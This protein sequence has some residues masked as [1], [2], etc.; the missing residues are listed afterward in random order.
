M[1]VNK[2]MLQASMVAL[3]LVCFS[4]IARAGYLV[5]L[6]FNNGETWYC[7]QDNNN[8]YSHTGKLA[9]AYDFTTGGYGETFGRD[10]LSPVYGKVVEVVGCIVDNAFNDG[11]YKGTC[12][13][14]NNGGWGNTILI[15]DI[16]TGKYI[17]IAHMKQWS[18]PTDIIVGSIVDIG[19]KIGEVGQSGYSSNPHLHIQMQSKPGSTQSIKFNF[20]EGPVTEGYYVDSELTLKSFV[21]DDTSDKS[22][23]HETST[24]SA[25][26]SSTFEENPLYPLNYTTGAR[27]YHAKVMSIYNPPWYK[28]SFTP[29]KTGYFLVSVKCKC[30]SSRDPKAQYMIYSSD[31]PD[32][33][34]TV[35]L[36]QQVCTE[37]A[38]HFLIGTTFKANKKYYIRLR[39]QTYKKW[40]SADGVKFVRVWGPK[41]QSISKASSF[42]RLPARLLRRAKSQAASSSNSADR[43]TSGSA[44]KMP[45]A[46]HNAQ[47][48]EGS[49]GG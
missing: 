20:V 11:I 36:D 32:I 31:D 27:S 24:Y 47:K 35:Y 44:R 40:I 33:Y 10:I 22:L 1:S 4:G 19:E 6:P 2:R 45:P 12:A 48:A 41:H 15:Q 46:H 26:K 16:A 43:T 30:A 23:S 13:T 38:W 17:R 3:L 21:L 9:Y 34:T 49:T 14:C 7:T 8:P 37:D 18:T 28:W 5:Y 42:K 39:G 29:N 25:S